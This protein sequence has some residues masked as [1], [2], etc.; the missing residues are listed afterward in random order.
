ML[1][2][3]QKLQPEV[4]EQ[5]LN[6]MLKQISDSEAVVD[7]LDS[8]RNEILTPVRAE[9]VS[10]L[11]ESK[12]GSLFNLVFGV[13]GLAFGLLAIGLT[14]FSV[15]EPEMQSR[16]V[17]VDNSLNDVNARLS[18]IERQTILTD[19]RVRIA[20]IERLDPIDGTPLTAAE[21]E[22]QFPLN[23][24]R[25][26]LQNENREIQIRP[27]ATGLDRTETQPWW[28]YCR[29]EVF[30]DGGLLSDSAA[31]DIITV[32]RL[33]EELPDLGKLNWREGDVVT[34]FGLYSFSVT[35]IQ[36]TELQGRDR[37]DPTNAVYLRLMPDR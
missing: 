6:A 7:N 25:I 11:A 19:E 33:N 12:R 20:L 10:L 35:R 21:G 4:L 34:L 5:Q 27:M 1:R 13:V 16:M 9:L 23:S 8:I 29:V 26:L 14:V 32:D 31:N 24:V 36:S 37:A 17:R 2:E 15:F 18:G 3:H 22:I 30:I 28:K